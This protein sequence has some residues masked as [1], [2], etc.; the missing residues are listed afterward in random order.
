MLYVDLYCER[1]AAGVWNE[2]LN[3]L[4]NLAFWLAAATVVWRCKRQH[5]PLDEE[6]RTLLALLVGIGAASLAF[7][8]FANRLT[9]A[10]DVLAIALYLHA[11]LALYLRRVWRWPWALAWR[12]AWLGVPA[13]AL[14]SGAATLAWQRAGIEPAAYLGAW[15]VLL[16]VVADSARRGSPALQPLA[17]AAGLFLI[18][19][20]LRQI[21]LPLCPQWPPGT[22]FG[23]HLLNAVTLGLT[24]WALA[25]AMAVAPVQRI[26]APDCLVSFSD[27]ENR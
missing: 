12:T 16:L 18:S 9:N 25:V 27:R 20:V 11:W 22:H 17:L 19:V 4:S 13:F 3:A 7:H 26:K 24:A 10:A 15:S 5:I 2:P 21:D 8:M 1:T 23:W 6:L 14:L